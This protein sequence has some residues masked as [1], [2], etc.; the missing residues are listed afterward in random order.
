MTEDYHVSSAVI[1][2]AVDKIKQ[3]I[4]AISEYEGAEVHG[5]NPEGKIVISI[6]GHGRRGV[7]ETLEHIAKIDTVISCNLVYHQ[8][9]NETQ[10]QENAET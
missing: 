8:Y 7:V 9:D 6:E 4:S 10:N 3:T 5:F 2:C 1:Y